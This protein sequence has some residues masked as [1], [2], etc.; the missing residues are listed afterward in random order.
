MNKRI[1]QIA[2]FALIGILVCSCNDISKGAQGWMADVNEGDN[3]E[4][5]YH[6][7]ENDGIK[8]FLPKVFERY[9]AVDYEKVLDSIVSK[10][11]I[12]VE[13]K[14]LKELRDMDGNFY[15]YFEPESFSSLTVNT[16]EYM[17]LRKEDAQQLLGIMRQSYEELIKD[18]KLSYK[19]VTASYS[20]AASVQV[21]KAIFKVKNPSEKKESYQTN[22][23]VSSNDKTF[24]IKL[25]TGNEVNFDPYL[26]KIIL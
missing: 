8:V 15:I 4:G 10:E 12:E 18:T 9:S 2:F 13:K 21:F 16:L 17:P 20:E 5:T 6:F 11:N 24:F 25:I 26:K 14:R 22:Y 1:K 19:K 7:L 23:F 3:L